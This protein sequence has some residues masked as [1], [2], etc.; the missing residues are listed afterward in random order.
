MVTLISGLGDGVRQRFLLVGKQDCPQNF[1]FKK[2][3]KENTTVNTN[4]A[5][6]LGDTLRQKS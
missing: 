3:V 2:I 4:K 5:H 1:M 6:G